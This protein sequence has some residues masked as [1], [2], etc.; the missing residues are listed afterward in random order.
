MAKHDSLKISASAEPRENLGQTKWKDRLILRRYR[1]PASG[2]SE[3]D[4]ATRI[5]HGGVGYFFPLGTP[6]METAAARAEQIYQTILESGWSSV[7]QQFSRELILSFE[8]CL[9][10]VL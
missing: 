10:P 2:E 4:L 7:F 1:F 9:N 8:W 6:D 5:E 3:Q